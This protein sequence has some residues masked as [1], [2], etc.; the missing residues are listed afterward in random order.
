VGLITETKPST[1]PRCRHE[2]DAAT[3]PTEDVRPRPGDVSVCI[4]CQGVNLFA[5]D[6]TLRMPTPE[7][8][9]RLRGSDAWPQIQRIVHA[10]LRVKR[11]TP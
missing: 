9:Q 6:L 8:L 2:V 10:M 3:H 11:R 5:E 4:G 1:C 7:E